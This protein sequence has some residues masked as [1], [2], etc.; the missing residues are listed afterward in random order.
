[1]FY[2]MWFYLFLFQFVRKGGDW[3][4]EY[5][6]CRVGLGFGAPGVVRLV[7]VVNK[8]IVAG[9]FGN[10]GRGFGNLDVL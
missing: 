10:R 6:R 4:S 9:F 2:I 5:S 1:M 3:S 7:T 8:V